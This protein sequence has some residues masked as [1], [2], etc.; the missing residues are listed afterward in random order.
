MRDET[1]RGKKLKLHLLSKITNI[2]NTLY[3]AGRTLDDKPCDVDASINKASF[4]N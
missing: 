2:K 1:K 4:V 3:R